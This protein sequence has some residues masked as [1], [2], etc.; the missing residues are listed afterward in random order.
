MEI[1]FSRKEF[2]QFV[3]FMS[4]ILLC[5]FGWIGAVFTPDDLSLVTW[6]ELQIRAAQQKYSHEIR[7]LREACTH[8]ESLLEAP[9]DPIRAQFEYNHV[10]D[11][12]DQMS[13]PAT[14]LFY[15][16]LLSSANSVRNWSLGIA[17]LADAQNSLQML[18]VQLVTRDE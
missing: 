4:I 2:I 8:L 9:Q 14:I 13:S 17:E 6:E 10:L 7:Q 16:E 1:E 11:L 3:V 12:E 15:Q 18:K 5:I